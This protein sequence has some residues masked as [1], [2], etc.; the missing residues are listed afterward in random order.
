MPDMTTVGFNVPEELVDEL[1]VIKRQWDAAEAHTVSRSEVAREALSVGL[2]AL[3][4]LDEEYDR[5][6]TTRDRRAIVREGLKAYFEADEG[7]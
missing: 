2:E 4:L 6:F 1:D 5:P 3:Q 7:S